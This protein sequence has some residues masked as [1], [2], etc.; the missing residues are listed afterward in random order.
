M[1]ANRTQ[2]RQITCLCDQITGNFKRI[3][4]DELQK[5]LPQ[6][7]VNALGCS[8]CLISLQ[9]RKIQISYFTVAVLR[10]FRGNDVL[11]SKLPIGGTPNL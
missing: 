10:I 8:V 1:L 4:R 5:N 7:F 6:E 9:Y 2:K 11:T 3:A